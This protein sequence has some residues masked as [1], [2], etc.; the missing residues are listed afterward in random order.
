M[1][2]HVDEVALLPGAGAWFTGRARTPGGDPAAGRAGNLSHRR[3]HLPTDLARARRV[4]LGAMGLRPDDL[5][6]MQQV[7]GATVATVSARTPRG[8]E[9]RGVDGLV[10]AETGRALGVQ[11]ADC[12]P[13]LLA[14]DAGPV[15]AVHVGRRG[16]MAGVV[17]GVLQEMG[18]A[19]APPSSIHAAIGPAIGGCC[20]EV[21][22]DLR[23]VVSRRHPVAAA[24]T[25]WGT[26]SL[27]IAAA[28]CARLDA[29]GVARTVGPPGCTRCDADGRWFSHRHDP[30]AGR[31]L[32]VVVRLRTTRTAAA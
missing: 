15:A 25:T 32:G 24:T 5:H 19:G 8:A 17:A 29:A 22:A 16:L 26:P 10:T 20:Y 30:G 11:V 7:H 3:P 27:D 2:P 14:S 9:L 28:V 12:V 13:L 31:Q 18:R 23:A 21:P 6:L 4:T 1:R